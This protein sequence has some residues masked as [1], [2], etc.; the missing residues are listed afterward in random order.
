M[1]EFY[2]LYYKRKTFLTLNL[3]ISCACNRAASVISTKR[4]DEYSLTY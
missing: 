2:L 3:P 1:G 4:T